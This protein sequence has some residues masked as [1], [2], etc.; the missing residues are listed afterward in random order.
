V[1]TSDLNALLTARA[2]A[3]DGRARALRLTNGM[4]QAEIAA[5]CQ[6]SPG[7]I[8]LWEGGRR[9]PRGTPAIRYGLLLQRLAQTVRA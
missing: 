9:V 3:A 8:S 4:S 2:A 5:W 6:V 7:A 1:K